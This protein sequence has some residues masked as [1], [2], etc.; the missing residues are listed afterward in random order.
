MRKC[1]EISLRGMRA[2][3]TQLHKEE[4]EGEF[5]AL[6]KNY[7]KERSFPFSYLLCFGAGEKTCA[8]HKMAYT[9]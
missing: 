2:W 6:R 1:T 4:A 8:R 5:A 7:A 9:R 3:K